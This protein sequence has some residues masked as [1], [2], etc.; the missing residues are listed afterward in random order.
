MTPHALLSSS[1]SLGSQP[2]QASP[3]GQVLSSTTADS[4]REA[5][6]DGL[7]PLVGIAGYLV[8][9]LVFVLLAILTLVSF[10]QLFWFFSSVNVVLALYSIYKASAG[11]HAYWRLSRRE[12]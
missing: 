3:A 12:S 5:R 7:P 1:S 8:H 2:W 4:A 10:G 9:G 6:P 11:L